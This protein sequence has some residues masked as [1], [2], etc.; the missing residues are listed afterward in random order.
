MKHFVMIPLFLF[1]I[2]AFSIDLPKPKILNPPQTDLNFSAMTESVKSAG[3][4]K[5]SDER[6]KAL[7][8]AG[9]MRRAMMASA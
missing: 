5:N 8:K 2:T 9:M 3:V 4:L 7:D 1:G 6:I